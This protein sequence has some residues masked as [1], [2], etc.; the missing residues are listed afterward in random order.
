MNQEKF[1]LNKAK[2]EAKKHEGKST[3]FIGELK[4]DKTEKQEDLL[5]EELEARFWSNV[6]KE[7]LNEIKN[8]EDFKRIVIKD[9]EN[10]IELGKNVDGYN[11][12]LALQTVL[13]IKGLGIYKKEFKEKLNEVKNNEDF[14][15]AVI[16]DLEWDIKEGKNSNGGYADCALHAILS[17]KDLVIYEKEFQ[18]KL[19]KVKNDEDFKKEV[20]K[21]LE[22]DIKLGKKGNA[23]N[24]K[25]A[26][27]IISSMKDLGIYEKEFQEKL[28]DIKNDKEFKKAVIK[29]LEESIELNAK[30]ALYTISSLKNISEFW[31]DLAQEKRAKMA[32]DNKEG[33]DIPKR[34][35][36]R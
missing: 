3:S 10:N 9:L 15:R 11:A 25:W 34:P 12:S 35:E 8:D 26:L 29:R 4:I 22:S 31:Q 24:A 5:P 36:I 32:R 17:I 16:K 1:N 14:K 6:Y 20:M 7:K 30:W 13:S 21:E 18:E 23:A 19:N 33:G 2:R 28:N 27:Y